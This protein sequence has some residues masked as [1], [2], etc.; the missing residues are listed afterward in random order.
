MGLLIGAL[1][2]VGALVVY[3]RWRQQR[4]KSYHLSS[5]ISLA[6]LSD[7]PLQVSPL[8]APPTLYRNNIDNDSDTA[9]YD[10]MDA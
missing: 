9:L 2:G 5:L 7:M 3:I 6:A 8:E 10:N 1:V 4:T